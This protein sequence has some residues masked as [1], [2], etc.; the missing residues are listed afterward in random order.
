[1][2]G[3]YTGIFKTLNRTCLSIFLESS[4][5]VTLIGFSTMQFTGVC[6]FL[7]EFERVVDVGQKFILY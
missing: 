3:I 4:I 1:M 7:I 2:T 6:N 5:V